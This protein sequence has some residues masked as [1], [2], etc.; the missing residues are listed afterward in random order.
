MRGMRNIVA[1]DYGNVDPK[2]I[3]EVATIHIPEVCSV[4]EKFFAGQVIVHYN[5]GSLQQ[6][7]APDGD[8][9]WITRPRTNEVHHWG[10][11]FFFR[12]RL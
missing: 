10:R 11:T 4:I 8:Q 1:H 7:L 6:L 2:I 9:A 5:L 12:F 3:W